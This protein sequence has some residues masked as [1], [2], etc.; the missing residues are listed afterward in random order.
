MVVIVDPG[1]CH[2]CL[3]DAVAACCKLPASEAGFIRL[4]RVYRLHRLNGLQAKRW[5]LPPAHC[6]LVYQP[7]A[8]CQPPAARC[9]MVDG[10]S[11]VR[12]PLPAASCQLAPTMLPAASQ[13]LTQQT[14]EI[15]WTQ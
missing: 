9:Q 5:P 8:S 7:A 13:V 10:L 6:Q 4:N 1:F 3:K 11:S 15:Q 12:C 14:L 2:S